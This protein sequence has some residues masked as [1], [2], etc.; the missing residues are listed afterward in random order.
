MKIDYIIEKG[1]AVRP[2]LQ[3]A[4]ISFYLPSLFEE[5]EDKFDEL[6]QMDVILAERTVIAHKVG[7][8]SHLNYSEDYKT[9]TLIIEFNTYPG[10]K[11]TRYPDPA[12]VFSQIRFVMN[13]VTKEHAEALLS[14][15]EES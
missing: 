15:K 12:D 13:R 10:P 14:R 3:N 1:A 4:E 11:G 6:D 2:F 5:F 9:A 7:R 8:I